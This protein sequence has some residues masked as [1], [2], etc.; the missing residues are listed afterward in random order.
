MFVAAPPR[1]ATGCLARRCLEEVP[2]G[3][4]LT[5]YG[6][7]PTRPRGNVRVAKPR[8]RDEQSAAQQHQWLFVDDRL[9]IE[10]KPRHPRNALNWKPRNAAFQ[11]NGHNIKATNFLSHCIRLVVLAI[12]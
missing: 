10:V 11:R 1:P 4:Y 5:V 7:S 3:R 12:L 9:A 6:W 8:L 2:Q